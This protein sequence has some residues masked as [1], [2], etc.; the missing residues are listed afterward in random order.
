MCINSFPLMTCLYQSDALYHKPKKIFH[1]EREAPLFLFCHVIK[2]TFCNAKI[3]CFKYT[4]ETC[5]N[6]WKYISNVSK[7]CIHIMTY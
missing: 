2:Y 3:D 7:V 4:F 1:I 5:Q 6:I